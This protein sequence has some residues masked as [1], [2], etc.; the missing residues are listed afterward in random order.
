MA[1]TPP[2]GVGD[3][4]VAAPEPGTGAMTPA[5]L[6]EVVVAAVLWLGLV[7]GS[8]VVGG[9]APLTALASDGCGTSSEGG[10]ALICEPE[11]SLLLFG[12]IGLLWIL[13]LVGVLLSAVTIVRGLT[14]GRPVWPWPFAGLG[15]GLVGVALLFL[16]LVVLTR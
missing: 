8:L 2:E 16:D 14:T 15:V 13:L 4:P 7:L 3:Q 9:L 12:G 5:R 6:V 10:G 11:G 1:T